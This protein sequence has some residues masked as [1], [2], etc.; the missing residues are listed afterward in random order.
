MR[1]VLIGSCLHTPPGSLRA[2]TLPAFGAHLAALD[3]EGLQVS[4]AFV[5]D[6]LGSTAA[7]AHRLLLQAFP[8]ASLM[9]LH[10]QDPRMSE[11][12]RERATVGDLYRRMAW[13]RN[14]LRARALFEGADFLLSIDGDILPPPS[15]L[16][17]LVA[18]DRPWCAGLVCNTPPPDDCWA[19]NV[20]DFTSDARRHV[21]FRP[22]L[23]RGGPCEITGAACLYRQDFLER[24]WWA[25]DPA[26]EDVGLGRLAR[27]AGL[28]GWYLPVVCEHLMVEEQLS[29][30]RERCP[31]AACALTCLEAEAGIGKGPSK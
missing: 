19:W 5:L 25:P 6:G 30:H 26:G 4:H 18:E 11:V 22:D 8:D 23:E 20:M 7:G 1:R 14:H 28:R 16:Q 13:V 9:M 10:D 17:R 15:L 29:A 21:H 12:R 2:R 24:I 3:L 31:L 27:Q